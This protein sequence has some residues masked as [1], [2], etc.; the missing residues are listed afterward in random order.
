MKLCDNQSNKIKRNKACFLTVIEIDSHK[1]DIAAKK[2]RNKNCEPMPLS[3]GG[4]V[5]MGSGAK[6]YLQNHWRREFVGEQG[7]VLPTEPPLEGA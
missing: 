7:N 1:S 2:N 5:F 3:T 4:R 6:Y